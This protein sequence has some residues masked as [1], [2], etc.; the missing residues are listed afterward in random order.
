VRRARFK[1]QA[2]QS[3]RHRPP[4]QPAEHWGLADYG[5]LFDET[6]AIAEYDGEHDRAAAEAQAGAC[7]V[8][9]WLLRNPMD[10]PPDK[11]PMCGA[12]DRPND[13]L[14]AIGLVHP[15]A[16][17]WLHLDCS[18]PWRSARLAAATA[19][20]RAMAIPVPAMPTAPMP[21]S[22]TTD[23]VTRHQEESDAQR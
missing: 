18:P 9:E 2:A 11:C 16:R 19:S 14:L 12:A 8:S 3:T 10:S 13:P 6:A 21:P 5:C 20:L 23:S 15:T 22:Q 1:E 4:Q 17:T 7:G